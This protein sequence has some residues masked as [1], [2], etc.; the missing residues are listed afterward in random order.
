[1]NNSSSDFASGRVS[2]H[3]PRTTKTVEN[4]LLESWG[5]IMQLTYTID[6]MHCSG[7]AAKVAGALTTVSG[8]RA[9]DVRLEDGRVKIDANRSLDTA[10]LQMALSG[11]GAFKVSRLLSDEGAPVARTPVEGRLSRVWPLI[12][13]LTSVGL[14]A[15]IKNTPVAFSAHWWHSAMLDYMAGFFLLFGMLKIFNLRQFAKMFG[16]YDPL[17]AA[18]P[19]WALVYPFVEIALGSAFLL[20]SAV[21]FANVAV[22]VLL[23]VGMVGIW[24]KLNANEELSCACLG[25]VFDVPIT[26]L[27][28]AENGAMVGMAAAML[29]LR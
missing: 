12:A 6:G 4:E 26:R 1:M 22:V 29:I 21:D 24:R 2:E 25:G 16:Q 7:C 20:R 27:T 13:M 19:G 23:G 11:S 14:F 3:P 9:V 17:A 10:E 15:L 28:L 5:R 18:I 8:V